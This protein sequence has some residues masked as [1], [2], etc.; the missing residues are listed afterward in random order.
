MRLELWCGVTN[1]VR[2]VNDRLQTSFLRELHHPWAP[3]WRRDGSL[4]G[5]RVRTAQRTIF[6]RVPNPNRAGM[7]S[8]LRQRE[9]RT[10]VWARSATDE[11]EIAD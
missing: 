6:P 11:W 7:A 1:D 10:D 4:W 2:E 5:W 8:A 9:A 3:V